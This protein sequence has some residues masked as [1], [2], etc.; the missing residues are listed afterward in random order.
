MNSIPK[1]AGTPLYQPFVKVQL[2][3]IFPDPFSSQAVSS[4]CASLCDAPVFVHFYSLGVEMLGVDAL[5]VGILG[6]GCLFPSLEPSDSSSLGARLSW[7]LL[8]LLVIC[9]MLVLIH[10]G[11]REGRTY[12]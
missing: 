2:I 1:A 7:T 11:G 4:L 12:P 6:V 3:I 8:L 10:A 5:G 9:A